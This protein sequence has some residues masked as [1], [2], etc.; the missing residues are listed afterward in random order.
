MWSKAHE[1]EKN[2]ILKKKINLDLR[3][4]THKYNTY[5]KICDPAYVRCKSS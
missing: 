5:S 3:L 2:K 1:T 4:T